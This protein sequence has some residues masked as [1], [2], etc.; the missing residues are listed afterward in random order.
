[1]QWL[2]IVVLLNLQDSLA[3]LTDGSHVGSDAL[4]QPQVVSRNDPLKKVPLAI[5]ISVVHFIS[6]FLFIN[7]NIKCKVKILHQVVVF[8]LSSPSISM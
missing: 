5:S 3:D 4:R 1:M 7:K 6:D 8:I 2:D